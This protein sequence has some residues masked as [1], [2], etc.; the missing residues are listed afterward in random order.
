MAR[1]FSTLGC[2][3]ADLRTAVAVAKRH[4]LD[5]LELRAL[6]D[7]INLP[8]YLASEYGTPEGFG[9]A[10]QEIG[11]RIAVLDTSL[12]LADATGAER[13]QFLAF[14][15]WAEAA[16]VHWLRAFDGGAKATERAAISAAASTMR[17]WREVRADSDLKVDIM[18]ETH[19]RLFTAAAVRRFL[20]ASPDAAILWDAHHTWKLGGEDPVATW[21]QIREHVVHIHVKDSVPVPTASHPYKYVLPGAGDFPM[22]ALRAALEADHFDGVVS[23]EWEKL[24]H[25]ELP[26]IDEALRAAAARG[27]W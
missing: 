18:V 20:S 2:P 27:W 25:P 9:A 5:A 17:W 14:V 13:E 6:A 19:N 23:L 12:H 11:I 8:A 1:A 16:G 22:A 15:P 10:M 21:R 3:E 26:T 24:W 7:T 4:H